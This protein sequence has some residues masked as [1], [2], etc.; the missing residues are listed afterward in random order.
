[1]K[2]GWESDNKERNRVIELFRLSRDYEGLVGGTNTERNDYIISNVE[3]LCAV[4]NDYDI[5][6]VD[7]H[8][9]VGRI[10]V[11]VVA[12]D[13]DND[14]THLGVTINTNGDWTKNT[15]VDLAY[16]KIIMGDNPRNYYY[17]EM[18]KTDFYGYYTNRNHT[19]YVNKNKMCYVIIRLIFDDGG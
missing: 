12:D 19:I 10:S 11:L 16:D 14:V 6:I 9:L 18:E 17:G 8:L 3:L 5:N 2:L 13:G 4:V 15:D 1:M 7:E